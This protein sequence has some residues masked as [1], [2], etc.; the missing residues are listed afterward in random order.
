MWMPA[1]YRR[2][3][4]ERTMN[5]DMALG[6]ALG[7]VT[8]LYMAAIGEGKRQKRERCLKIAEEGLPDQN[9][10]EQRA[11]IRA[12]KPSLDDAEIKRMLNE[13]NRHFES[14]AEYIAM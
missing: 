6:K 3:N 7:S 10:P 8:D 9:N 12:L 11:A 4:Q 14:C 5:I 2:G 1:D 13:A